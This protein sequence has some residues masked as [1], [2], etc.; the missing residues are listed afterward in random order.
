MKITLEEVRRIAALAQLDFPEDDL[1]RL[2]GE[3]D[4]IL[5]YIDQLSELDVEGIEPASPLTAEHPPPRED[6]AG[7]CLTN[8]EALTNAP[9]SG[10]G[11]FKVPRVIG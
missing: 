3:L 6:N 1:H 7:E 8:E 4:R 11:H 2:A 9:E 10:R 5:E